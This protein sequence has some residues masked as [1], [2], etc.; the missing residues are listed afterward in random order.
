KLVTVMS[1]KKKDDFLIHRV[2]LHFRMFPVF[3]STLSPMFHVK[4]FCV[5]GLPS[6][7]PAGDVSRETSLR[8]SAQRFR[9][10][11]QLAKLDPLFARGRSRGAGSLP[12][13]AA[14]CIA[15][16]SASTA[17]RPRASA[18]NSGPPRTDGNP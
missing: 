9:A 1:L 2:V 12:R 17:A 10:A 4:H 14:R 8:K 16:T 5:K 6:Q 15:S 7:A 18:A 13:R 3:R 11:S